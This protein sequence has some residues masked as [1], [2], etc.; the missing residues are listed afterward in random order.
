MFSVLAAKSK[1][2]AANKTGS[3][4]STQRP[5]FLQANCI[6]CGLC[7]FIC[8]EGCIEGK[9]KN[10]YNADFEYCKGCGICA[11]ECPAKAIEMIEESRF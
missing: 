11:E 7:K 1:T 9:E 8:P 3:W 10:A 6:N 5:K 2:S 4:R